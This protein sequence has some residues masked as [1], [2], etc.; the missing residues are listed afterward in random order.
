MIH[1]GAAEAVVSVAVE[2]AAEVAPAAVSRFGGFVLL[3]VVAP[4]IASVVGSCCEQRLSRLS[5][6]IGEASL[7]LPRSA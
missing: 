6:R 5:I 4:G 1:V 7:I 2:A 3:L